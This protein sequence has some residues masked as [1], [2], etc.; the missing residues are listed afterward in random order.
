MFKNVKVTDGDTIYDLEKEYPN[1]MEAEVPVRVIPT[2]LYRVNEVDLLIWVNKTYPSKK[3]QEAFWEA[4]GVNTRDSLG[5]YL[6]DVEDALRRL[7]GQPT[8][9]D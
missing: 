3:K 5:L 1:L 7:N 6:W 8:G 9:W 4:L 2:I